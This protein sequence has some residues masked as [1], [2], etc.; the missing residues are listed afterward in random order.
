MAVTLDVKHVDDL[1][2]NMREVARLLDIHSHIRAEGIKG[3]R[4]VQ[5]LHKSAI[6]LVVACWE[7]YVEDLVNAGLAF[8]I[9][10]CRDPKSLPAALRTRVGGKYSGVNAWSLA[11]DGWKQALKDNLTEMLAKTTGAFNTPKS[12]QV[13]E[14]FLKSL[15]IS[16]LSSCWKWKGR[17]VARVCK[18]LDDLISL[19]G[20]IAH[21]VEATSSVT[22]ADVLKARELVGF[23]SAK[24]SNHVRTEVH[25]QTGHYPWGRITYRKV[26]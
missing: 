14:L 15:G 20:A 16:N 12:A 1:I 3:R 23:L 13:D 6:V 5:V 21:R 18:V 25:R 8:C 11:G 22:R 9:E 10:N 26:G 7:A 24:S 2:S 19:R 4:D 17:S